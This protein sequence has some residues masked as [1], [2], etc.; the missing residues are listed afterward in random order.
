MFEMNEEEVTTHEREEKS[1]YIQQPIR[2]WQGVLRRYKKAT[3]ARLGVGLGQIPY[4][5]S[6]LG[7]PSIEGGFKVY[8]TSSYIRR[9]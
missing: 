1:L 5:I 9:I 6:F 4:I 3:R 7:G 8:D 2:M